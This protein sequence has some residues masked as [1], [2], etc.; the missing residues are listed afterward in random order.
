MKHYA[1]IGRI[2]G[3]DEDSCVTCTADSPEQARE[4]FERELWEGQNT[5]IERDW[6]FR[7]HGC[8]IFI[9]HTL[10]SATEIKPV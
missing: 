2:P 7:N 3:D 4:H 5:P 6:V 9:N 8:Y 10:D 1:V